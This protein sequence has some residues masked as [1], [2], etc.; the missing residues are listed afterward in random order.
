MTMPSPTDQQLLDTWR[1]GDRRAGEL[2]FERHFESVHRFFS[3]RV[4]REAE[5]LTQRT[6]LACEE[7]KD[8]IRGTCSFRTFLFS[9]ARNLLG[10]HYRCKRR[11]EDRTQQYTGSLVD[12]APSTSSI[13]IA[14]QEHDGLHAAFR[15]LPEEH[16]RVL[17]M[18][19]WDQRTSADIAREL[20]LP[21]GTVRTRIRKAKTLLRAHMEHAARSRSHAWC[22]TERRS[23]VRR[24]V[25]RS[26]SPARVAARSSSWTIPNAA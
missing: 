12:P 20:D 8:R 23:T 19:Y 11:R 18:F 14:H 1:G 4:G 26:S 13:L 5:D 10:K 21:H 16:R 24:G 6:F 3:R 2:L 7:S 25:A 17:E 9:L 22:S 15:W